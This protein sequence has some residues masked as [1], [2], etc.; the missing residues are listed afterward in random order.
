MGGFLFNAQTVTSCNTD[1]TY[2]TD[3]YGA[4]KG[5]D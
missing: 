5:S 2:V 1:F 3:V 4:F